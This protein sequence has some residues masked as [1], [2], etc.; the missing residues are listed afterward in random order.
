M[1][2]AM[3]NDE[4]YEACARCYELEDNGTWTLRQSSKCG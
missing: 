3:L 1:R 2:S 4:R